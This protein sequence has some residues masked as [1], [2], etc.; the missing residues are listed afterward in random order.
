MSLT[1]YHKQRNKDALEA[2]ELMWK[3]PPTLTDMRE[4]IKRNEEILKKIQDSKK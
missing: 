2:V 3:H 4:Q 1:D